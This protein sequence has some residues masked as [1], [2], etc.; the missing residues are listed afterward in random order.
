M[1]G[2]I[3][4]VFWDCPEKVIQQ[5]HKRPAESWEPRTCG[6]RREA[7]GERRGVEDWLKVGGP[8]GI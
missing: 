2:E 8:A 4:L 5:A 3:I 1:V 7:Q 6:Q